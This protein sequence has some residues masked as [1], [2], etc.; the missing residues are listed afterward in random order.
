[1]RI[2]MAPRT[3]SVNA[4]TSPL[5]PPRSL[6]HGSFP[7]VAIPSPIDPPT[8]LAPE[9]A[10]SDRH[11]DESHHTRQH[12]RGRIPANAIGVWLGRSRQ[13]RNAR[14]V[15]VATGHGEL[16]LHALLGVLW[17]VAMDEV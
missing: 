3:Y 14:Q 8:E 7:L 12:Q 9:H 17:H 13:A 1:M 2:S 6:C 4:A 11:T 16:G 15:S 10:E 5:Q